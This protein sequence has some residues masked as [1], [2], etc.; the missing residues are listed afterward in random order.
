MLFT[1]E[2]LI[3]F[4]DKGVALGAS[5]MIVVTDGLGQCEPPVYVMHDEN[6]LMM[7]QRC[8]RSREDISTDLYYLDKPKRAQIYRSRQVQD[9]LRRRYGSLEPSG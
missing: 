9:I 4:F 1:I 7:R 5:H 2:E 8:Q 3:T 6:Y